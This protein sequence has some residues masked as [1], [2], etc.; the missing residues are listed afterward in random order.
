[1]PSFEINGRVYHIAVEYALDKIGGRWKLPILWRLKDRPWRYGE[2][3]K[4]IQ[5][6][7]T[8]M[9]TQQ[10]RELEEDGFVHRQ[11]FPQVPPKVEYTLTRQGQM[12][13]PLI[14]ELRV[15]GEGLLSS[16][17]KGNPA[18]GK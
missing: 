10:L 9:L 3:K 8:K 16:T 13:I 5:G 4:N 15:L 1:M 17:S 14:H 11:L 6:I 2:L 7:T 18:P 12:V